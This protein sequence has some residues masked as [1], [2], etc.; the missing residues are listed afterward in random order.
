MM[1]AEAFDHVESKADLYDHLKNNLQVSEHNHELTFLTDVLALLRDV[2]QR[3]GEADPWRRERTHGDERPP[4][5]H[6]HEV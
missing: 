3:L 6:R 5:C 2:H 4:S 1:M